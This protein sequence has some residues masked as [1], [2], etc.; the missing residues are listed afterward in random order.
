VEFHELFERVVADDVGV[1]DEKGGVG[2]VFEDVPGEGERASCAHWFWFLGAGDFNA[3]FDLPFLDEVHHDLGPVI[4]GEDNFVAACFFEG[5]NLVDDHGF[6]TCNKKEGGG[7]GGRVREA[8]WERKS[9][10][11]G[12]G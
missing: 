12:V 1:E 5:F 4:D 11:G 2:V 6:V 8:E 3:E 9:E 7:G 10:S